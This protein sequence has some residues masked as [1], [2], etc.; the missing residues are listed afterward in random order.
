MLKIAFHLHNDG[1]EDVDFSNVEIANPGVGGTP[2]LAV[3]IPTLLVS[4]NKYEIISL[5]N[6]AAKLPAKLSNYI[7]GNISGAAEYCEKH[8]VDYLV[9]DPK[10][11][12]KG[13]EKNIDVSFFQKY[14]KCNFLLWANNFISIKQQKN[15]LSCPNVLRIINVGREQYDLYRDCSFFDKTTYIYNAYPFDIIDK[16]SLQPNYLRPNHVI[17]I[18]SLIPTK[19]FHYLAK[20][21]KEVLKEIPDAE[22]FVIGSGALYDR[23]NK[24]GKYGIASEDYENYF[25]PYLE[26]CGKIHDSVHFLGV[27]GSE[28]YD[29]MKHCKLGVPN[30]SGASETFGYTAVEMQSAGCK[31]TTKKCPGYIDTVVDKGSLYTNPEKQLATYIIKFLNNK[32]TDNYKETIEELKQKFSPQI[33]VKEWEKLFDSDLTQ[34]AVSYKINN[35]YRLKYCKEVIRKYVPDS[36][37]K[38]IPSIERLYSLRNK[39]FKF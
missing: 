24:L 20:A 36:I 11:L 5:S 17:Y 25:M 2:F 28:K 37:K 29:V 12:P 10:Y 31:V 27:L 33:I 32:N 15:M 14:P 9:I 21:W 3:L 23:T 1:I 8:Q 6:K 39:I 30:P 13:V 35:N 4:L 18:G 34:K 7:C 19:G 22:L 16:F 38:I 26:K